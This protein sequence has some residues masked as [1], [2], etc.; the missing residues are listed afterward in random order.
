MKG[1]EGWRSGLR[2]TSAQNLE[3]CHAIVRAHR[4]RDFA[5]ERRLR[6][7]LLVGQDTLTQTSAARVLGV[8]QNAV[9]RWVM[10]FKRGGTASLRRVRTR[11]GP[12]PRLSAAQCKRLRRYIVLGPEECG[13]DTGVWDG[14]LVGVLIQQKFGV[15]FSVQ[16]VRKIMHDLH[17]SVKKPKRRSAEA[18]L[19]VQRK[20]LTKTLPGIKEEAK[21]DGGIVAVEDEVTFKQIGTAHTTWGPIGEDI[22]VK[23]K[24]GS[25]SCKLFAATTIGSN[26]SLS[27]KFH[28]GTF[29]TVSFVGFLKH[30]TTRYCTPSQ[31]KVHLI[32]D[33]A[34]YHTGAVSWVA[35]HSD[36]IALHFLPPHSPNLNPQEEVWQGTKRLA[37]HNRYFPTAK[38]LRDTVRRRLNRYQANPAALRGIIHRLL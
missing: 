24:P 33:G 6:G 11:T 19:H 22:D 26:P 35:A 29:N 31:P 32:L 8:T 28:E 23:C 1:R 13:F 4:S 37:T 16:H 7:I 27:F 14:K 17:L 12:K 34:S 18:S 5:Y 30:L 2:L 3:V 15:S 10:A 20:W 25:G 9:T 21:K 38:G 36:K